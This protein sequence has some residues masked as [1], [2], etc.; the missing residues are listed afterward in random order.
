MLLSENRFLINLDIVEEPVFLK[1]WKFV[2]LDYCKLQTSKHLIAAGAD[3]NQF[4]N[5]GCYFLADF[6]LVHA[7]YFKSNDAIGA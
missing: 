5:K 7:P 6:L 3:V 4:F 2:P 1:V